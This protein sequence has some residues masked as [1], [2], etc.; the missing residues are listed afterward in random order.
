MKSMGISPAQMKSGN[1]P[2]ASKISLNGLPVITLPLPYSLQI[3][4]V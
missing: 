1:T 2:S 4:L 3:E